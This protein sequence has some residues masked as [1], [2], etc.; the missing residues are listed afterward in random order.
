MTGRIHLAIVGGGLAGITMAIYLQKFPHLS[1]DVFESA[2]EFSEQG[3]GIGL[4]DL[5]LRAFDEIIP[6]VAEFLKSKAGAVAIGASR[7]GSGS[8]VGTVV[9]DLEGDTGLAMN[10]ASM[11]K[12]LLEL[13]PSEILHAGKKLL[14]LEQTD[15][16]LQLSFQDGVTLSF[17]AVIGA[18]GIFSSVRKHVLECYPGDHMASPAGWWDS[19]HAVPVEKAKAMLGEESLDIDREYAWAGEDAFMMHAPVE[20]GTMIQCIISAVE[21]DHN[22]ARKR[23]LTREVL[24]EIFGAGWLANPVTNGMVELMLEQENPREYSMWDHKSTPAYARGRACIVGDAAHTTTPWQ[25]AGAGLAIEDALVL[26]HLLSNVSSP[27]ELE[28]AFKAFDKVRRPRCQAVIDSGRATGRLFCGQNPDVGLSAE[29][30]GNAL[31]PL[32]AHLD[33]LSL[34]SHKE[35]ALNN[36]KAIQAS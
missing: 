7:V 14:A 24:E 20:N 36:L 34:D 11:L 25:G 12:A 17:D 28:D 22:L 6:S 8:G 18:D 10:R 26:G 5:A 27:Q 21:R 33:T 35:A 16:A 31:G 9:A 15:S 1:V 13:L 19:R 32:F 4:S 30:M 2:P 23:P 3:L 29:K